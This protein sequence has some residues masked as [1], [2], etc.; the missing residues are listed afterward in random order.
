MTAFIHR[1]V[2]VELSVDEDGREVTAYAA[3]FGVPA[4]VRDHEGHYLE[5]IDK[6]A[7]T[8]AINRAKPQGGRDYW[9]TSVFYNHGMTLYGTPSERFS[10]PI[11]MTRHIEADSRG[12]LT[13]T[14]Y[15]ETSLG[16]EILQLVRD[17]AIKAQSFTGQIVRSDPNLRRGQ[18]HR[19]TGGK[20]PTVTRLELGLK[21]YGPTPVPVYSDAEIVG[22]RSMDLAAVRALGA[23]LLSAAPEQD[24]PA[25][26]GNDAAPNEA[27]VADGSPSL[28]E[29]PA[30]QIPFKRSLEA[31]LMSRGIKL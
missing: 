12:L 1:S 23:A 7:F 6:G 20:L 22:V 21:E 19:P 14:R 25:S 4:E 8:R 31:A 26:A 28:E 24:A 9:L 2:P 29:R 11:G 30:Q 27:L 16:D 15:S 17:G 5:N 18:T 10:A 3:V 13:V